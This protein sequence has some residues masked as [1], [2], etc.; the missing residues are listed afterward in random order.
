MGQGA[1]GGKLGPYK[2]EVLRRFAMGET[3]KS[4]AADYGVTRGAVLHAART[5]GVKGVPKTEKRN[6]DIPVAVEMYESGLTIRE[7]AG[8]LKINRGVMGRTLG[9]HTEIRKPDPVYYDDTVF[10]EINEHSAYWAGFLMADGCIHE[11]RGSGQQVL[12]LSLKSS[13][14][15][16]IEKF[17]AFMKTN[18]TIGRAIRRGRFEYSTIAITSQKLCDTLSKYGLGV[19]KTYNAVVSSRVEF[20]RHFWRG[21]IDGDGGVYNKKKIK[22][23]ETVH[24]PQIGFVGTPAVCKQLAN[25]INRLIPTCRPSITK[26]THTN[27]IKHINVCSWHARELAFILYGNCTISLDRKQQVASEL[28]LYPSISERMRA[29]CKRIFSPAGESWCGKCRM[30]KSTDCFGMS[31]QTGNGFRSTCKTCRSNERKESR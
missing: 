6:E 1:N 25:F 18:A 12:S 17:K 30:Y 7:I 8:Q 28:M 2:A 21:M 26:C 10:D 23:G 11:K 24:E 14:E 19:R 29:K 3:A 20:D 4:I 16:H 13:D 27:V 31:T 9:R 15:S 5:A 22:T